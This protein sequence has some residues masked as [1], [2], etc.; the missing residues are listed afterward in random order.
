MTPLKGPSWSSGVFYIY[1]VHTIEHKISTRV[2]C[3]VS[4]IDKREI[5]WVN[6]IYI[7]RVTRYFLLFVAKGDN[8]T[9]SI[10][11]VYCFMH[12]GIV[13]PSKT[14][15]IWSE[16]YVIIC[17]HNVHILTCSYRSLHCCMKWDTV[18]KT[19]LKR[20]NV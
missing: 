7:N 20:L 10:I 4:K 3:K 19:I 16:C 18:S 8:S 12:W 9:D 15:F 17:R 6:Y 2:Y 1:N 13:P 11:A 5:I 14:N